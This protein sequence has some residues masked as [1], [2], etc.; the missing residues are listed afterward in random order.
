M[1][2]NS[3]KELRRKADILG[4]LP[5]RGTTVWAGFCNVSG[6]CSY[7]S[8]S[9]YIPLGGSPHS[10]SFLTTFPLLHMVPCGLCLL[11]ERIKSDQHE[12]VAPTADLAG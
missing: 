5:G 1:P 9:L 11:R 7:T 2:Q 8:L 6:Q 10:G 12:R 4:G 3:N